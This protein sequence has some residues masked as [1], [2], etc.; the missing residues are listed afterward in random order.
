MTAQW[1]DYRPVDKEAQA[2]WR[3]EIAGL[4]EVIA[5]Q[6]LGRFDH[7]GARQALFAAT[8]LLDTN[9]LWSGGTR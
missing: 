9:D 3:V 6:R 5:T 2:R 1:L 4:W 7:D 8:T